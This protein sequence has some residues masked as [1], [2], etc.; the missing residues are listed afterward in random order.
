M[1]VCLLPP[2]WG[3]QHHGLERYITSF[4]VTIPDN[5]QACILREE[6]D[7]ESLAKHKASEDALAHVNS[8]AKLLY[9]SRQNT[10]SMLTVYS[11]ALGLALKKVSQRSGYTRNHHFPRIAEICKWLN[12]P[13]QGL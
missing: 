13:Q 8:A 12:W 11:L 7:G 6:A 4:P 1:Q 3:Y 5:Q 2:A 10:L 9:V